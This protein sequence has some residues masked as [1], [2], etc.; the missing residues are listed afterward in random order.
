MFDF[1]RNVF[2]P[3]SNYR[4][5]ETPRPYEFLMTE[6]CVDSVCECIAPAAQKKHE[7]IAY[8]YGR[9]DGHTTLA[10]GAIRPDAVT[11]PGSFSVPAPEMAKLVK[12]IR[13]NGLQLI[14]QLHTH[15]RQAYHSDGDIDGLKL[16]CNGYVSI[17]LPDY[18]IHLPSFEDAAFY[19]YRRGHGFTSLEKHNIRI[20]PRRL[21]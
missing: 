18:G 11:T 20:T 5:I 10:V 21:L 7:G 4:R 12:E 9:T 1:F 17:V 8:M 15:P 13:R 6:D 14:C 19:F 3:K 2:F 16:I